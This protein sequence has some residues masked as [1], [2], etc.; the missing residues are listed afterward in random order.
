[1]ANA[2]ELAQFEKIINGL[3]SP[4]ND[5]RTN[6]EKMFEQTKQQPDLLFRALIK[7]LCESQK[8]AVRAFVSVMLRQN[9]HKEEMWSKVSPPTQDYFKQSLLNLLKN[10]HSKEIRKKVSDLI[11]VLASK[12]FS[13]DAPSSSAGWPQLFPCLF[14]VAQSSHSLHRISVYNV[15]EV[16]AEFSIETVRPHFL[17]VRQI[18]CIGLKDPQRATQLEALKAMVGLLIDMDSKDLENMSEVVPLL[19][20]T[21]M[22]AYDANDDDNV[23]ESVKI[24]VELARCK[25]TFFRH[26]LK[27][28]IDAMIKIASTERLDNSGRQMAFEF[29][30][31]MSETGKGMTRKLDSYADNVIKLA[32]NFMIDIK[33]SIDEWNSAVTP[34]DL[35]EENF[36]IGQEGIGRLAH[37]L[38]GAIFLPKAIPI[39]QK[40][41]S[42]PEWTCKHAALITLGHISDGCETELQA[43]LKQIMELVLPYTAYGKNARVQWAAVDAVAQFSDRFAPTLQQQFHQPVINSLLVCMNSQQPRVIAHSAL[44]LVDFCRG[45]GLHA[46]DGGYDASQIMSVYADSLLDTLQKI[47]NINNIKVQEA[48]VDAIAAVAAVCEKKFAKYY[49]SFMKGVKSILT[50]ATE[51]NQRELRGRAIGCIAVIAKAVGREQFAPDFKSVMDFLISTQKSGLAGDDPQY[52]YVALAL[53]RICQCVG[54]AFIPYLSFVIPPLLKSVGIDNA[55]QI[56]DVGNRNPDEGKEGFQ[57]MTVS[58]RHQ[59]DRRVTINTSLMDEQGTACQM[60]YQYANELKDGFF[61]YVDSAAKALVPLAHCPFNEMVRLAATAAL[62][63]LLTSAKMHF[64]KLGGNDD[65]YISNLWNF[66]FPVLLHSIQVE[67]HLD[68]LTDR[69][70]VFAECLDVVKLS[71]SEEQILSSNTLFSELIGDSIKRRNELDSSRKGQDFDQVEDAKVKEQ[72]ELEDMLLSN[73]NT[74]I[75]YMCKYCG[76]SYVDSFHKLLFPLFSPMLNSDRTPSEQTIGLCVMDSL[77]QYGGAKG[78]QYVEQFLPI[79]KKYALSDNVSIRQAAVFGIGVCAQSLGEKFASGGQDYIMTLLQVIGANGSRTEK[80]GPATDNAISAIGRICQSCY[81]ETPII[82]G[83]NLLEL[84]LG[85]LP[86]K[87]DEEEVSP[88]VDI[89]CHFVNQKNPHILGQNN[90]NLPKIVSVFG[91]AISAD[92]A[93][94]PTKQRINAIMNELQSSLPPHEM[95][96]VMNSFKQ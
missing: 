95:Q 75:L 30:L 57:S 35:D 2:N 15:I 68:N 10:E 4:D 34:D 21:V 1:M 39:I 13:S 42:S 25:P 76:P 87:D 43:Q 65:G 62:P 49:P 86:I 48:T 59:G 52:E 93:E 91:K 84:W 78:R 63:A 32:F 12:F 89:L 74:C 50:G 47:I 88:V 54:E 81:K 8:L 46:E 24:L 73:I 28:V 20:Q 71:C 67:I 85:M 9:L 16:L 64:E 53:S 69:L 55:F 38:G 11:G 18:L 19:F 14:E 82:E 83:K 96:Q 3:L 29:L 17:P 44:C 90:C 66:M 40:F 92:L 56:T 72:Y 94:E 79:T 31:T 77:V 61:P 5:L 7:L 70:D 22:A 6:S 60:L 36:C 58:I 23:C 80:N 26:A 45:L 27:D 37:S 33:T 41:L 51:Q